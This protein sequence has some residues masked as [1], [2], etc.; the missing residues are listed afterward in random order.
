LTGSSRIFPRSFLK[1]RADFS[2]R[3]SRTSWTV[4]TRSSIQGR[5]PVGRFGWRFR[6]DYNRGVAKQIDEE[7]E[8]HGAHWPFL[9]TGLF[10]GS[11][12]RLKLIKQRV[13][14]FVGQLPWY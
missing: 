11:L 14:E 5:C 9:V 12:E 13:D 2:V 3:R 7:I 1:S 8:K 10:N 4:A 6:H